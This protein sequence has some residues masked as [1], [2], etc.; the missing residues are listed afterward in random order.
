MTD[1]DIKRLRQF[2]DGAQD[3]RNQELRDTLAFYQWLHREALAATDACKARLRV[4]TGD[5]R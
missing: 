4:L 3:R 5:G 2:H 1:E